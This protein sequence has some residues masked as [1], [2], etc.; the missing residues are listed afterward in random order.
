[1]I[2]VVHNQATDEERTQLMTF[3][4]RITN[5]HHP[6]TTVMV[7]D[8]EAIVLDEQKIDIAVLEVIKQFNAV[9]SIISIKTPYQLVSRAF[10]TKAT[11]ILI[12]ESHYGIPVII[13]GDADPV[14]MA[15]PWAVENREQLLSTA[16]AVRRAG[17]VVLRGGVFKP[18]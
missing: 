3:L 18:R 17:A 15:G 13:G 5:N 8:R 6:I 12:G 9:K 16:R 1:M 2:I 7:G 4:R 11:S 10:Q 14:V